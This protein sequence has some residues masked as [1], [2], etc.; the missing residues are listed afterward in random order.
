MNILQLTL[1]YKPSLNGVVIT[2]SNLHRELLA[3]GHQSLIVAP[4]FPGYVETD[5]QVVRL[6][7]LPNP[8]YSEY[9]LLLPWRTGKLLQKI[10]QTPIDIVHTHQPFLI[11]GLAGRLAKIL[12]A[13]L[14]FSYHSR[15]ELKTHYLPF[16]TENFK[17]TVVL[18]KVV[19]YCNAC[20]AVVAETASL[21]NF[22]VSNGVTTEIHLIPAGLTK[23]METQEKAETLKKRLGLNPKDFV[24]MANSRL[25]IRDK[26]LD[27]LFRV[28]ATLSRLEANIKFLIV[29]DGPDRQKLQEYVFKEGFASRCS[30]TGFI[31]NE[32]LSAYYGAAEVFAHAALNETQALVL[33]EALSAGLPV[34]ALKG[35]GAADIIINGSNGFLAD[36]EKSFVDYLL[37]LVGS[38][39]LRKKLAKS[40][41]ITAAG[42]TTQKHLEKT[43]SLYGQLIQND[44]K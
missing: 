21:K 11:G 28:F 19:K 24:I 16:L 3:A 23:T 39:S 29:S 31:A 43:L 14:V 32:R 7:S 36:D 22:L 34:V 1:A 12:G 9:P 25:V 8:F 44:R 37:K 10:G 38:Q 15:Y 27:F 17:K 20:S 4:H 42:Y 13:P 6:P 18:R 30:F 26:N 40:A 35:P 33:T 41:K 5:A 2:T